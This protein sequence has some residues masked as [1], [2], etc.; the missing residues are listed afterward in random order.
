MHYCLSRHLTGDDHA[1]NSDE[2]RVVLAR[3]G[4][5]HLSGTAIVFNSLRSVRT[6]IPRVLGVGF[7]LFV[8]LG[9]P[10]TAQ[11]FGRG[12]HSGF[13][14]HPGFSAHPGFQ[15]R[16][17]FRD[18]HP[19]FF[20]HHPFFHQ[21]F[22]FGGIFAAPPVIAPAYPGPI[23]RYYPCYPYFPYYSC[24]PPYPYLPFP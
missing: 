14:G 9:S 24:Y 11:G 2:H 10:A 20:H 19:F 17:I 8:V 6:A 3:Q 12:P 1:A 5:R 22:I 7:A 23:Y 16:F 4:R 15:H 18:H 21:R 13:A